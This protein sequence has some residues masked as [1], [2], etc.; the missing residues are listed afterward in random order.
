MGPVDVT[1]GTRL[2]RVAGPIGVVEFVVQGEKVVR[3][4]AILR[5]HIKG[6]SPEAATI[7]LQRRGWTVT[8]IPST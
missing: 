7:I 5:K 8:E 3:A 2:F 4:A 6:F 1:A